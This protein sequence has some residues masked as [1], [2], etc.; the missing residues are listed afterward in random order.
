MLRIT[1]KGGKTATVPLAPGT[2]EAVEAYVGDRTIGAL[3]V[4][5]SGARWHRS[6]AW[7][8]SSAVGES[9]RPRQSG[10][11]STPNDL[12]LAYVTLFLESFGLTMHPKTPWPPSV[13]ERT[14]CADDYRRRTEWAGRRVSTLAKSARRERS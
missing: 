2:A 4:T 14:G 9:G 13:K 6:E 7:R 5:A 1:R 12:R 8:D 10:A 11:A 3:F